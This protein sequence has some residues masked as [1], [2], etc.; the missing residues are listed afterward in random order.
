MKSAFELHTVANLRDRLSQTTLLY[1]STDAAP[2][3][4]RNLPLLFSYIIVMKQ[5]IKSIS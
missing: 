5:D 4:C 3:F 2:Q 1:S